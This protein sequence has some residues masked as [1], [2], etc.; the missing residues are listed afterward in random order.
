MDYGITSLAGVGSEFLS[1]H[2]QNKDAELHCSSRGLNSFT[3]RQN[4][5]A[6][7]PALIGVFAFSWLL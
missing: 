4:G 1:S 6:S 2:H 3:W 7:E 5:L